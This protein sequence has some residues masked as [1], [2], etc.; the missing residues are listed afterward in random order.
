[1]FCWSFSLAR[2]FTT[3]TFVFNDYETTTTPNHL[4]SGN[5]HRLMIM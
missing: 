4:L 1:M 2:N 3:T 5:E